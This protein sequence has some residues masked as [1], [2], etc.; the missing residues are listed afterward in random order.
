MALIVEDGTYKV[1][2]NSYA[3]T[4]DAD[5]YFAARGIDAWADVENKDAMM[6][7]GCQYLD[8]N[9]GSRFPGIPT[10]STQALQWPRTGA[11][12]RDGREAAV[13]AIPAEIKYAQFELALRASQGDLDPDQDRGGQIASEQLGELARSFFPGA[14]AGTTKPYVDKVLSRWIGSGGAMVRLERG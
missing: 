10:T 12:D 8:A 9:Y 4:V 3:P 11:V 13:N 14:P 5:A 6:V 1:D 7:R 2:A